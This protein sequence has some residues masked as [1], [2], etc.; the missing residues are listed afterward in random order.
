MP[1]TP[2]DCILDTNILLHYIREDV[3]SLGLEKRYSLL[4]R[5]R[6][7]LISVVSEGE[8]RSLALQF[9]WGPKRV[10]RLD[11]L[12]ERLV[13][14]PLDL[15]G[16]IDSYAEIEHFCR[17]I[18]RPIGENDAWI[19]ATAHATGALLLTTDRDFDALT[20]DFLARDWIDPAAFV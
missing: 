4:R 14:V 3:L 20:P 17:S 12:L 11:K 6:E 8:I 2:L 15:T 5:I 9:G 10:D 18:G 19:A 7:P 1:D 13:V 16:V